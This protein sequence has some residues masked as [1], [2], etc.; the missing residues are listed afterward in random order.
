MP[1]V[2]LLPDLVKVINVHINSDQLNFHNTKFKFTM[3]NQE[4][5]TVNVTIYT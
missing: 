5:D 4:H 3:I 2:F 1:T